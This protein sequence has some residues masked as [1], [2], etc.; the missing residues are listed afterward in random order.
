MEQTKD[1]I[2]KI[3]KQ[4]GEF[5]NRI[6]ELTE[7]IKS[8]T[9]AKLDETANNLRSHLDESL[10]KAGEDIEAQVK[11]WEIKVKELREKGPDEAKKEYEEITNNIR[12]K[13]NE[14][15]SKLKELMK[16]SGVAADELRTG[17]KA[18]LS[19]LKDSLAKAKDKFK[20]P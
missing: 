18:A 6:D 9:K 17:A 8:E 4:L 13:T 12:T 2:E 19:V 11:E 1:F 7:E 10:T 14:L 5:G 15:N 3:E 16:S 20:Q